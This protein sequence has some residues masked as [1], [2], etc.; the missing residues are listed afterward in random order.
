MDPR[1]LREFLPTFGTEAEP[2]EGRRLAPSARMLRVEEVVRRFR[3]LNLRLV[4]VWK[5]HWRL[6]M[7]EPDAGQRHCDSVLGAGRR[8]RHTAAGAPQARLISSADA[9]RA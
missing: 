2:Q 8:E 4:R 1:R 5:P 6:V 7:E 9:G 3:A